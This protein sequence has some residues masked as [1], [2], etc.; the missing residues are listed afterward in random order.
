MISES[1]LQTVKKSV[2]TETVVKTDIDHSNLIKTGELIETIEPEHCKNSSDEIPNTVHSRIV[3]INRYVYLGIPEHPLTGSEQFK[4]LGIDVVINC[5]KEINYPTDTKYNFEIVKYNVVDGDHL[6]FLKYIDKLYAKLNNFIKNRKK[7]YIHC[8]QCISRSPAFLV[9]YY[10]KRKHMCYES[11]HKLIKK[12]RPI[13][14]I[15][16]EFINILSSLDDNE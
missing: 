4:Q 14:N 15:N 8:A 7:V 16:E 12:K 5:A 6:S 1:E 10:M 11:A 2:D 13:I 9:Y 3:K